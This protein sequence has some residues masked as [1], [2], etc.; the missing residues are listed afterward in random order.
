MGWCR[1]CESEQQDMTSKNQCRS[2]N[3]IRIRKH[4]QKRTKQQRQDERRK[5]AEKHGRIY[6]T[7]EERKQWAKF[8]KE[9]RKIIEKLK[10]NKDTNRRSGKSKKSKWQ[11]M[12]QA[13]IFRYRY[14][15][16]PEFN[17]K[18]R[19]RAH[20]RRMKNRG[21]RIGD[22]FRRAIKSNSTT[23]TAEKFVGYTTAD[24]KEHLEKQFT[25][26]MNWEKFMA[27]EIHIDHIIPLSSFDRTSEEEVRAA[28]HLSNLQP[29]W[30]KENLKK[31][32]RRDGQLL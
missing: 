1:Y 15:N 20:E 26:G 11:G 13:E 25:E 4:A 17:L 7:C 5:L 31:G 16:D 3:N 27:G 9:T 28:W 19:L 29:M 22:K 21:Y 24:L 30:A 2:C 6:R 18:Q 10:P 23:P 12:T 32:A 8:K 14:R